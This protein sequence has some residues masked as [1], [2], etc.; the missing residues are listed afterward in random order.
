MVQI[1]DVQSEVLEHNVWSDSDVEVLK[2]DL[3][4]SLR[5][6]GFVINGKSKLDMLGGAKT[7][8]RNI[9]QVAKNAKLIEQAKF[10]MH[11]RELIKK[12]SVSLDEINPM[13]IELDL[14]QVKAGSYEEKIFRWWNL[15]WWSVPYQRAFGRQMRFILWDRTHDAPFG[16]ISL[17]SPILKQAVRDRSLCIPRESL[18]YWVNRSMYAQRV[19][20]LPPYNELI[21][22]KMVAL[23]LGSNEISN[24]YNE[25]YKGKETLM[26]KRS[27]DSK[28]LFVTTTSAFG[29]SSMYNRLIYN[30]EPIAENLGYTEGYGSFQISEGLYER[31]L[32]YLDSKGE[33]IRRGYGS[34]PSRKMK[35]IGLACRKL[36]LANYTY[37]GIKR[38]YYLFSYVNNLRQVIA[39]QEEPIYKNYHLSDLFEFWKL[40]WMEK[41][42]EKMRHLHKFD[43]NKHISDIEA[44][45]NGG[46][47]DEC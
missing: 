32:S 7:D 19:G 22:G 12:H 14:V 10:V 27:I 5:H 23:S 9:Q 30:N 34:G 13:E 39:R 42:M 46:S 26:V 20:A 3:K 21:G 35:L 40:R 18:D 36:G 16:I 33:N 17:T 11:N 43:M 6:H 41:R 28:L 8:L 15:T 31:L 24:A 1:D 44:L 29:R 37:H 47:S 45:C 4:E 2:N 38:E 25:K